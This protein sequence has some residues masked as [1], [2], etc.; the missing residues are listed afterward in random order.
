MN[1]ALITK[2]SIHIYHFIFDLDTYE[3]HLLLQVCNE[4]IADNEQKLG[5]SGE[6]KFIHMMVNGGGL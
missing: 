4:I 3:I 2:Y 6:S 5:K 1:F